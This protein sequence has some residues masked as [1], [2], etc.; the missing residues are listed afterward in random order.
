MGVFFPPLNVRLRGRIINVAADGKEPLILP[1]ISSSVQSLR[2]HLSHP[3][4]ETAAPPH[5]NPPSLFH[6]FLDFSMT[7]WIY[8]LTRKVIAKFRPTLLLPRRRNFLRLLILKSSPPPP[9][10]GFPYKLQ[11]GSLS[12]AASDPP[13]ALPLCPAPFFTMSSLFFCSLHTPSLH[14]PPFSY[15]PHVFLSL[16]APPLALSISADSTNYKVKG[17]LPFYIFAHPKVRL[18]A[19]PSVPGSPLVS[20]YSC[21]HTLK[22]FQIAVIRLSSTNKKIC[23]SWS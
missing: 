13:H 10:L 15:F 20:V 19:G 6:N 17:E 4:G 9:P 3:Q 11:M 12:A 8:F 1:R 14:R 5:P 7:H 22:D 2:R 23:F 16:S 21:I 18:R